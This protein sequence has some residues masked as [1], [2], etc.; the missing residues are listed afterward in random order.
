MSEAHMNTTDIRLARGAADGDVD[1]DVAVIGGGP[2]GSTAATLIAKE[3][4][5]VIQLERDHFPR[6]KVGESLIPASFDVLDR[7]DVL[8]HMRRSPFV[9][10]YSVQFITGKGRESAP[11]YFHETDPSEKS[12]TWQVVRSEF[13]QM[14]LDNSRDH[15]VEVHEGVAVQEI[16]FEGERAV[17]VRAKMADGEV[18]DIRTRVVVDG[19]GQRAI[20][21]RQRKL[22]EPDPL[23]RMAAFFTHFEGAE[24]G[25]GVDEGATIIAHT[26]ESNSWVWYIPLHDDRVSV[27]VVGPIDYLIKGRQGDPQKVFDDE[28]AICPGV[29]DRLAEATQAAEIRVLNDFSYMSR[30]LAGDGWVLTGDAFGFLDPMYSTGVLLALRSG[31]MAADSICAALEAGAPTGERLSIHEDRLRAGFKSFHLLVY[32]FYNKEF[33]FGRFLK[34]HP[35]HRQAI[36]DILVGDVFD[37]DF[38]KLFHD[39][40][41]MIELPGYTEPPLRLEASA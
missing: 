24:R 20:L 12:Q 15:G 8:E 11:F 34:A 19:S 29:R 16:L 26:E 28:I 14:M 3:G 23:L 38:T 10:K 41:E 30:E 33:S 18:R 35:E 36:V 13:D 17:G 1:F 7:L 39:L 37:R 21:A 32:A 25:E 4:R 31:E 5:R 27:G 6:F 9:K 22:I 2:A 40:G